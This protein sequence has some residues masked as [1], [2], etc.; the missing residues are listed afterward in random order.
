[1]YDIILV[2]WWAS[3]LFFCANN[4]NHSKLILESSNRIWSKILLSWWWR[5]N[6]T[7]LNVLPTTYYW[8]NTKILPSIFHKFWSNEM[9]NRL[10]KNKLNSKIED[11]WRVFPVT[12]KSI[13]ILDILVSKSQKNN[14]TILKNE[15]VKDII[16]NKDSRTIITEKQKIDSKNVIIA[17][18]GKTFPNLWASDFAYKIAD[19]FWIKQSLLKTPV[20][21][22]V[23][24][25]DNFSEISGSSFETKIDIFYKSKKINQTNWKLLFTHRWLS[26]PV[27]FNATL[28]ISDFLSKKKLHTDKIQDF[29]LKIT[30]QEKTKKLNKVIN[31]QEFLETQIKS[32]RWNNEAKVTYW[33]ILISELKNNFESKNHKWLFFLWECLDITWETGWYNLQRCRSSAFHCNDCLER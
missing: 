11:N 21:S 23:N 18:W 29:K 5:C 14:T 30:F 2:W 28:L 16:Q 26:W 19:K 32:F 31:W 22:W 20:L 12:D 24:T 27:I 10:K 7:N 17:T 33:W 25:F 8:Q 3:S 9:I 13:S 6:Y 15:K 1:M 4:K